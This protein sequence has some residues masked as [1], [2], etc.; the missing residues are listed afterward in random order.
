MQYH[1]LNKSNND[2]LIVFFCGWGFD[3]H[4]FEFLNSNG[5]DVLI[6]YDYSSVDVFNID[7]AKYEKKYLIAWSMGVFVA[8]LL[9]DNF[10]QFDKKIAINGTPFPVNNDFGIPQR[11]FDLTLK[12]VEQSLQGKFYKNMFLTNEDF[13]RFVFPKREIENC[14][15][16]LFNIS[17]LAKNEN[18]KYT[19]FYDLAIISDF[20]KIIP[21]KNQIRFWNDKVTIIN[22][23]N[24]HFSF[25][26]FGSWE[27]I[28][29][30]MPIQKK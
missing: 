24:G 16:E 11:I 14:R 1:W 3:F 10:M 23:E 18:R 12:N 4:S 25:Y 2:K 17:R 26:N 20:D 6:V 5:F 7:F 15:Q 8:N 30:C 27:N 21:T 22:L 9:K 29:L 19:S 28:L 13:E